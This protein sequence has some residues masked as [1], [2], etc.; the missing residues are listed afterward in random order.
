MALFN[1]LKRGLV[2]AAVVSAA[3]VPAFAQTTLRVVPH[4]DLKIVDPIWTTAYI[5]RNHGY[6]VYDT[7]FST[8]AQGNV[9]PQMVDR[10]TVSPDQLTWTFTLRDGLVFH[11]DKPVT[12]EDVIASLKRWS[13]KDALGQKLWGFVKEI[14]GSMP[15]VSVFR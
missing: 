10:W 14:S 13:A 1:I 3:T 9:K 6:L 8:D 5:T 11:D 2:A 4:S 15:K 12:S 7:L